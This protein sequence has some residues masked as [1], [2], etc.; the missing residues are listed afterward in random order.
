LGPQIIR[1]RPAPHT[2]APIQSYALKVSPRGHFLNWQ[3]DPFGNWQARCVF[4]EKVRS[5]EILVDLVFEHQVINPVDFF[6]ESYAETYPF[7]YEPSLKV[8]LGPY[9]KREKPRAAFES[10]IAALPKRG[11]V[12]PFLVELSQRLAKD[13][14]Y[15]VRME[16]GV[17]TPE[18]TLT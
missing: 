1:L 17:Q 4:P 12:V 10:Y 3:Q 13:I 18:Q 16:P 2:R 15:V 7:K 11:G 14:S 5:L 6:V 8:E 9:L